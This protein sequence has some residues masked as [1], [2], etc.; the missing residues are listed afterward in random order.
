[1]KICCGSSASNENWSGPK[2]NA[3]YTLSPS[4][5]M[6]LGSSGSMCLWRKVKHIS[7]RQLL[8]FPKPSGEE[9]V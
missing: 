4:V 9:A 3:I 2:R 1:M 6:E 5:S 8:L 7:C